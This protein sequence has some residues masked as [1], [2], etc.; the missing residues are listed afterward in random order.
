MTWL[1]GFEP[2]IGTDAHDGSGDRWFTPPYVA[3]CL[4]ETLGG[5]WIDPCGDPSSPITARA[6][7]SLDIRKGDDGLIGSWPPGPAFCNP[8]YS[9]ASKWIEKCFCESLDRPVVAL[10]PLRPEGKAWH[11]WIWLYAHV[12]I[13]RGRFKFVGADGKTHGNAM[14]GTAFVCWGCD[15]GA[16]ADSLERRGVRSVVVGRLAALPW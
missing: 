15:A 3:D 4:D 1:P 12:V 5:L 2:V 14:I 8:P 16:L 7:A 6:H 10:L 9:N 13:P 11:A